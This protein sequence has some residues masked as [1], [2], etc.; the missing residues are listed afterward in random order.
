MAA[1]QMYL[2]GLMLGVRHGFDLDHITAIG[3]LVSAKVAA[4]ANSSV[5]FDQRT[6]K[7][8]SCILAGMYAV[9]HALV[10]T[11][12]GLGA[13]LFRMTLPA[14]IDPIMQKVVGITLL[15]LGLW[16]LYCIRVMKIHQSRGVILLNAIFK[17]KES[18]VLKLFKKELIPHDH[19][20]ADLCNPQCALAIG[21]LHGIGAETGTQVLLMTSM[22]GVNSIAG[23]LSMLGSFVLGMLIANIGLAIFMSES[24]FRAV[25]SGQLVS[26][27]NL[28]VAFFSIAVGLSFIVGRDDIFGL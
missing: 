20:P 27:I 17:T 24:Y 21:V 2:T 3:D 1:N 22:G 6:I 10:V 16:M 8:Q 23:S 12:L 13:L 14:W 11:M 26:A 4:N 19:D 5:S 28:L 15:M 7:V 18:I 25:I 9:G